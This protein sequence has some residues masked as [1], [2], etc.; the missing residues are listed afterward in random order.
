MIVLKIEYLMNG[1]MCGEGGK[2]ERKR[3]KVKKVRGRGDFS[4]VELDEKHD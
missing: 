2:N 1:V 4:G 3:F